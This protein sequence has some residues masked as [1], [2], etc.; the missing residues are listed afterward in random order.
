MD[1]NELMHYGVPGMKWGVRR[2]PAQLGRKKTSSSRFLLGKKR[3]K[4]KAKAETKAKT[5][6]EAPKEETAPKKKSVKEM[7]DEELNAAINRMRLEQTYVSLSPQKV[8]TGKKIAKTILNDVVVPAAT[9]VGRQ[10]VKTALTRAGNKTLAEVFKDFSE[11]DKIYTNN[12][13]K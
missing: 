3:S 12:K 7:S 1:N 9:D 11:A 8:S 5:K 2:T 10:M 4:P 13:K 6:S